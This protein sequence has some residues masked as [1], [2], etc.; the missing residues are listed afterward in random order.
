MEKDFIDYELY[1]IRGI[2]NVIS[3]NYRT[4]MDLQTLREEIQKNGISKLKKGSRNYYLGIELNGIIKGL[5][6]A[7]DG[8]DEGKPRLSARLKK[9]IEKEGI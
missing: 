6:G 5:M 2:R 8:P 4:W 1:D 9:L 3:E 7:E